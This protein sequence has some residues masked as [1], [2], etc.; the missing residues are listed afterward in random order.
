MTYRHTL[1]GRRALT[2]VTIAAGLLLTVSGC[3]GGVDDDKTG[4]SPKQSSAREKGKDDGGGK[5]D[6]T[7]AETVLA[8]V[9]G[10]NGLTLV[11]TSAE[12]DDGG[13]VT[14]TGKVTNNTGDIW[15]APNWKGTERELTVN[16][17][18]IAGANL[19]DQ[20]GKKK[21]LVLRDTSGRCLCSQFKGGVDQGATAEWFAQF[22]APP[23]GV[24][25]VDFQ[26]GSM[27]PAS[28]EISEG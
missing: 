14:V 5:S 16:G 17:A 2:A 10:E 28:I 27:P 24:T 22:P 23:E 21:Y 1:K 20:K 15:V 8:E 3:G 4:G 26:V 19:I 13:F 25:E 12:R 9:K 6:E 7:D 11:V 18:S